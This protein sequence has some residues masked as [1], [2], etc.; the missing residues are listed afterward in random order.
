MGT[1]TFS[2]SFYDDIGVDMVFGG[3]FDNDGVSILKGFVGYILEIR[4]Y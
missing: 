2:Y 3:K 1:R 4:L